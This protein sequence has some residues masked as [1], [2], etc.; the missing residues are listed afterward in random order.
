MIYWMT[1]AAFF[2]QDAKGAPAA[3]AE[4]NPYWWLPL[5]AIG[6]L[7]Y[8][9][10]IRPQKREQAK[11]QSLL[12]SLK[13]NDKVVTIGGIIGTIAAIS[14]DSDEVTVKV[15]ENTRMRFRRSSIQQVVTA[16]TEAEKS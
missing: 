5:V 3:D 16:E 12:D 15:D 8:F 1:T 2:A 9:M 10:M 7:F 4:Q 11:R 6:V 14:P 13:K